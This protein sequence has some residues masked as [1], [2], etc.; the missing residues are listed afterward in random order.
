M[1]QHQRQ[2]KFKPMPL[3]S[4]IPSLAAAPTSAPTLLNRLLARGRFRHIQVLLALEELGS[5]QRAADAIGT[6][7]P[8]VTQALAYLENLLEISLFDRHA[9]GVRPTAACQDLLPTARQLMQ[10]LAASMEAVAA[11]RRQGEGTVRVLAS[12]AAMCGLLID[13]LPAFSALH[14]GVVVTVAEAE[15]RAQWQAIARG[16]VDLAVCRLRSPLPEQWIFEPLCCDRMSV[17][18]RPSHPL[19]RKSV[20]DLT[21]L[22]AHTWLMLPNGTAARHHFEAFAAKFSVPARTSPLVTG[23]LNLVIAL[24]RQHDLLALMPLAAVKPQL[25]AGEL[26]EPAVNLNIA[27][28][29]IG[30]LRQR[31]GASPAAETLARFLVARSRTGSW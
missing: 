22:E 11:R 17:V 18:C 6:T 26:I 8:S 16:E 27:L 29:P 14:P 2:I 3:D 15:G 20:Q 7:Q 23:S 1:L 21:A 19:H 30:L 28:E 13:A 24:L 5:V 12:A 4:P 10:G 31:D 25:E 9:R